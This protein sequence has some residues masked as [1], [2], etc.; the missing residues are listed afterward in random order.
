MGV[1][2]DKNSLFLEIDNKLN[3]ALKKTK[4]IVDKCFVRSPVSM[5][6]IQQ[7]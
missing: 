4:K 6:S 5:P 2:K 3:L 1:F 7:I